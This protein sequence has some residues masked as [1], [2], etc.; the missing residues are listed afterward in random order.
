MK[1]SFNINSID[2][3]IVVDFNFIDIDNTFYY[4]NYLFSILKKYKDIY[5]VFNLYRIR[6]IPLPIILGFGKF[7]N[8]IKIYYDTRII[9]T[10]IVIR[11]KAMCKIVNSV[12]KLYN[13]NP[14]TFVTTSMNDAIDIFKTK[15]M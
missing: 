7:M 11:N 15:T 1:H 12:L 5:I 10:S 9:L 6:R 8:S 3:I 4:K 2:N 13:E 14:L